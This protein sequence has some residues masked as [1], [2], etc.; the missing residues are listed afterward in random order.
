MVKGLIIIW[1]P[2]DESTEDDYKKISK[3]FKVLNILCCALTI[4]IYEPILN[5]D[6]VKEN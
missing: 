2:E 6:S 5:C 3:N 4:D 1:K